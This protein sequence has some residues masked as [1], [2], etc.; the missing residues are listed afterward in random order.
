MRTKKE[1]RGIRVYKSDIR[2]LIA[3]YDE[4]DDD[5]AFTVSKNIAEEHKDVVVCHTTVG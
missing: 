1:N 2:R 5:D 3:A 4:V